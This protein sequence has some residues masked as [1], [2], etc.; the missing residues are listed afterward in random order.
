[1]RGIRCGPTEVFIVTGVCVAYLSPRRPRQ[2]EKH[3]DRPIDRRHRGRSQCAEAFAEALAGEV[4]DLVGH[5][6][7]GMAEAVVGVWFNSDA[8]VGRVDGVRGQ[9]ANGDRAGGVE[10]LVLD[11][12]HRARLASVAGA[13]SNSPDLPPFQYSSVVQNSEI[14]SMKAWSSA[15]VGLLAMSNDWRCASALN[16][17][18]VTSGTQY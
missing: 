7:T 14:E 11:D 13:A 3:Q 16:A 18:E 17:A 8:E 12:Q 10:L 5:G 1:M 2:P 9:Q 15:S 4:G 6:E